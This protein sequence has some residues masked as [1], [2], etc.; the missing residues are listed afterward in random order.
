MTSRLKFQPRQL[1]LMEVEYVLLA[2][3]G[4]DSK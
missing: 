2:G 4:G 1:T 3:R